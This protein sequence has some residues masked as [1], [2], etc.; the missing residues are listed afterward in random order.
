MSSAA[1]CV[2]TTT[3]LAGE[4]AVGS[5]YSLCAAGKYSLSASSSTCAFSCAAGTFSIAGSSSCTTCPAGYYSG[6]AGASSCVVCAAGKYSAAGASQ[7]TTCAAGTYASSASAADACLPCPAGFICSTSGLTSYSAQCTGSYNSAPGSAACTLVYSS[8]T[9]QRRRALSRAD[10]TFTAT[11][12]NA[13]AATLLG[14]AL[15]AQ[16]AGALGVS[17][18]YILVSAADTTCSG[19][20]GAPPTGV[21]VH[22]VFGSGDPINSDVLFGGAAKANP[23]DFVYVAP[24]GPLQSGTCTV[25]WTVILQTPVGAA[26]PTFGARSSAP[27]RSDV[28]AALAA[29][30]GADPA[31]ATGI[32]ATYAGEDS[33]AAAAEA[34]SGLSQATI[35]AIAGGVVGGA[36]LL[37]GAAAAGAYALQAAKAAQTAKLAVVAAPV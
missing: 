24:K 27:M 3:A 17:V 12:A 31:T 30:M 18:A 11:G 1:G 15:R 25:V 4:Y 36:A 29:Y 22:D 26:P 28:T 32:V 8:T 20:A 19:G 35:G 7:C 2:A 13:S 6:S 5:S 10:G 9:T 23:A 14:S 33:A 37:A 34:G 21:F 16:L